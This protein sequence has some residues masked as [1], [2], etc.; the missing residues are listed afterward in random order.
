VSVCFG[1]VGGGAWGTALAQII[2]TKSFD[3]RLWAYEPDTVD[4]INRHHENRQWLAGVPLSKRIVASGEVS[5]LSGCATLFLVPPA[6]HMRRLTH[7]LRPHIDVACPLVVCSKGIELSSGLLMHEVLAQ[8]MPNNP[9]LALSGPTFA[10]ETARG[11]PTS[12][13][14]ACQDTDKANGLCE[15]L[16]G[17]TFRPYVGD[18]VVG[19]LMGGAVK[20]V[21]A[22]GAGIVLG[23]GYGENARAA[24]ITRGIVEM[25]RIA[26]ACGAKRETVNGLAG[27]GDVILTC[28]S[29]KSR[30][31]SLG[32]RLGKG[33]SLQQVLDSRKTV[34]EGVATAKSL[35]ELAERKN[36]DMPLCRA[37]HD[38]LYEGADIDDRVR[39]LM[40]RPL[41]VEQEPAQDNVRH[42]KRVR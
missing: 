1:V 22:I 26:Q 25:A 28:M 34:A 16:S 7:Q 35:F 38:I 8:T 20:N 17:E 27:C 18:D 14:L 4:D 9:V 6:Q 3:V 37:V 21:L 23:R 30:S 41:T 11:L 10:D 12:A 36:I 42:I 40:T 19:C 15:M 24:M 5:F 31:Q 32:V 33:E 39:Q 13:L 2:A 29:E